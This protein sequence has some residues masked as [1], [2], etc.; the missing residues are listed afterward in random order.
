MTSIA[1]GHP[2]ATTTMTDVAL[3]TVGTTIAE[4]GM[5]IAAA[6]PQVATMTV[7][8][9]M[10]I[11]VVLLLPAQ[12]ILTTALAMAL[13][14][15]PTSNAPLQV[16]MATTGAAHPEATVVRH[17]DLEEMIDVDLLQIGTVVVL[18][19]TIAVVLLRA[20]TMTAAVRHLGVITVVLPP[21]HPAAATLHCASQRTQST[22]PMPTS[23]M[24][25]S[26]SASAGLVAF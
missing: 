8:V 11:A 7:V 4:V 26:T 3:N 10:T 6:P 13:L 19:A 22:S 17:Q 24:K 1:V 9:A 25:S 18:E 5:T 15:R 2:Q 16:A 21:V 14:L 23:Q 12:A 20:A